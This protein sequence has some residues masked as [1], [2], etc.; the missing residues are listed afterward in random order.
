[1]SRLCALVA[2]L[3]LPTVVFAED[4]PQWLGPRRDG[5]STEKVAPWKGELKVPWRQ[6]VGE[7]QG[8][9]VV[10]DGKVFM[11]SASRDKEE[12]MVQA[13]DA[14][15]G[16]PAWTYAYPRPAF[17]AM[18]VGR[19]TASTPSVAGG[20]VYTLGATGILTC[21]DAKAGIKVWQVDTAKKFDAPKLMFGVSGSPLVAGN[22]VFVNVGA[23]GAS[24]VAF[25]KDTGDVVWKQLDDKASY[26][27]P[28][29]YGPEK[30]PQ[31]VFLTQKG[32]V[33]LRAEDGKPQ[34]EFPFQDKL[35]ESSTT[36]VQIGDRLLVS[37][38]T[39]GSALVDVPREGKATQKW[40]NPDLTCYFSTPVPVGKDHIYLVTGTKPMGLKPPTPKATLWCI[41][42][43]NGKSL[44]KRE[45]V[46][47]YHASLVRTGDNKLLMVEEAGNLVL[48]EPDPKEYRELARAPICGETWAHPAV[49]NGLLY[50][51]DNKELVA[52]SLG[53]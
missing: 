22:K 27:S 24:V 44:W 18:F 12:E 32:L 26:S 1:M 9:P 4:W 51:R 25:D 31:V 53:K 29:L 19:G 16:K 13:F 47:K 2:L 46:G 37:S 17:K 33:G 36:P 34:W 35:K 49:A 40:L 50:I 8:A 43:A 3:T 21:V 48:L 23:K 11:L 20:K 52:V 28:I 39:Q 38:I 41:D 30:D 45:N 6:P 7:G 15:S 42:A 10:A 14:T 5:S